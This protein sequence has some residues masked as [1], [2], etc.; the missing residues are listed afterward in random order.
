MKIKGFQLAFMATLV[1]VG[2]ACTGT[3]ST[4]PT[5]TASTQPSGSP[6]A[7]APVTLKV[8]TRNYTV[9][10][11]TAAGSGPSPFFAVRDKWKTTHPNV[12]IE[13][14][15][16]PYDPQ[17]Q[18]LLLS[19]NGSIADKPDVFLMDNIWLGQFSENG[20]AANLDPYYAKWTGASD[21]FPY[22]AKWTGASDISDAYVASS[23]WNG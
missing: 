1:L 3:Q 16:V 20:L 11:P 14:S 19:Q 5:T 9:Q 18:R 7:A 17:Y 21:I 22:Y 13:L 23:K 15:G 2:N 6:A 8:W 4:P 10:D 12:S